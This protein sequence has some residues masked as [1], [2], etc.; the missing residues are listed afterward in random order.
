MSG[1]SSN[2]VAC[3]AGVRWEGRGG[4]VGGL[5]VEVRSTGGVPF[6]PLRF[7]NFPLH[8]PPL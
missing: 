6:L 2:G 3:V 7:F 5:H 4:G 1:E 8:T